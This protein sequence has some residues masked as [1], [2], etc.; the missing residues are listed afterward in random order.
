MAKILVVED[1]KPI[2]HLIKLSLTKE[3]HKCINAFDGIEAC[4]LIENQ[5]FDLILL[6][7][8]LPGIDG[9]DIMAFAKSVA[10]PVIF[11]TAMSST[12]H[13]VKGLRMGAEDYITK[14]FELAELT[15]RVDNVL[16]R[17]RKTLNNLYGI[18]IDF[19]EKIVS[20]DKHTITLTKLEYDLLIYLISNVNQT[21]TRAQLYEHVWEKDFEQNSR[22]VDMGIRRLKKKLEWDKE[23]TSIYN[24]G[25]RL[26][27]Q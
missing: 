12:D 19:D 21:L 2:A 22:S 11:L 1:E 4:D 13:K 20:K 25:Y 23:I 8:M 16:K 24:V 14:P 18:V 10:I 17:H 26:N 5:T 6:D 7:V 15:A 27:K 9:F 3:G